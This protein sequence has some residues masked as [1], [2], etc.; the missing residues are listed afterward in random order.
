MCFERLTINDGGG[1]ACRRHS[2]QGAGLPCDALKAVS[3][4]VFL[5]HGEDDQVVPIGASARNE[6]QILPNGTLK[7]DPG[8]SHGLFATHPDL[9][10]ADLLAFFEGNRH[11]WS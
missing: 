8:L 9:I 2:K 4:P 6:I 3:L 5:I 11:E 10:N 1:H 7:T